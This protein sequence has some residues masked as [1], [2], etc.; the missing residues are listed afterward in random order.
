[1]GKTVFTVFIGLFLPNLVLAHE[2]MQGGFIS[3]LSHPVLEV[4]PLLVMVSVGILS[5]QMCGRAI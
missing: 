1:M 3:G 2:L 5:A 4:V